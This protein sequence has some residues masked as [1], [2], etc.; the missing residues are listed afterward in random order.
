MPSISATDGRRPFDFACMRQASLPSTR[1][2]ASRAGSTTLADSSVLE[3]LKSR[4][5]EDAE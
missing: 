5:T 3:S 4:Y 2:R 1:L